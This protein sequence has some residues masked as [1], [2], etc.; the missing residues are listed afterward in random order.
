MQI[1]VDADAC[2]NAIKEILYRAAK[3]LS[4]NTTFV[5][6]LP[7]RVPKSPY[8]N[9]IQVP[10]G[11]D[12]ADQKIIELVQKDDLV[13]SA[14]I[15]MVAEVIKKG[16][17]ALNPRGAFYN[18]DNIGEY[19]TMR[20]VSDELRNSGVET[21]GPKPLSSSDRNFFANQLDRLLTQRIK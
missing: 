16:A 6:N 14:D 7:L 11:F 2:P 12:M 13:V 5:A 15:P 17:V 1:W 19:L 18:K 4:I 9:T 10:G 20:N 8:I 3:R 21:G